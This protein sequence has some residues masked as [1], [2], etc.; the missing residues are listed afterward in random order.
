MPR[1][2]LL[3]GGRNPRRRRWSRAAAQP[4]PANRSASAAA[5]TAKTWHGLETERDRFATPRVAPS[6]GATPQF[7]FIGS[8]AADREASCRHYDIHMPWTA[9]LPLLRLSHT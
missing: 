2:G 5:R 6:S 9:R 7:L 1:T 3:P 8:E 4:P